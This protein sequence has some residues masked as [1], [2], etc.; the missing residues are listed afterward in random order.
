MNYWK[1]F[2]YDTDKLHFAQ[3]KGFK[4]LDLLTRNG[5]KVRTVPAICMDI[6]TKDFVDIDS[7]FPLANYCVEQNAEM[8]ILCAN[9][10][11]N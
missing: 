3:G 5:L 1:T 7:T 2:L 10:L 11:S 4:V 8:L 6:N 9:W